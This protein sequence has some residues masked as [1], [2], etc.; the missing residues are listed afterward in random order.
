MYALAGFR[1]NKKLPYLRPLASSRASTQDQLDRV[2]AHYSLLLLR[3]NQLDQRMS[4]IA[5]ENGNQKPSQKHLEELGRMLR[6]AYMTLRHT[7]HLR[8]KWLMKVQDGTPF[9]VPP[10]YQ[11]AVDAL[12]RMREELGIPGTAVEEQVVEDQTEEVEDPVSVSTTT[13]ST[14][15][16]AVSTSTTQAA[17]DTS[18]TTV[19]AAGL[20]TTTSTT[21]S[22]ADLTSQ[23]GSIDFGTNPLS[24]F[25]GVTGE[26]L[27]PGTLPLTGNS[28]ITGPLG[29]GMQNPITNPLLDIGRTPLRPGGGFDTSFRF[30]RPSTSGRG[31]PPAPVPTNG[32]RIQQSINSRLA[33]DQISSQSN[34]GART[35]AP[36]IA[37]QLWKPLPQMPPLSQTQLSPRTNPFTSQSGPNTSIP[38]T[39]L[40]S[41][42]NQV[43]STAGNN[44]FT[45]MLADW[46][47]SVVGNQPVAR[48]SYDK[49][50][51]RQLA[52]FT[53]HPVDFPRF[54]D[55]FLEAVDGSHHSDAYK[56][57][58]LINKLDD[59]SKKLVVGFQPDYYQEALGVLY[60]RFA[61]AH[62]VTD[63]IYAT[64][65]AMPNMVRC[66]DPEVVFEQFCVVKGILT[67]IQRQNLD[68]TLE[69]Y[70][71]ETVYQKFPKKMGHLYIDAQSLHTPRLSPYLD[72]IEQSLAAFMGRARLDQKLAMR[73]SGHSSS[74]AQRGQIP[75]VRDSTSRF[76]RQVQFVESSLSSPPPSSTAVLATSATDQQ[77]GKVKG[78]CAGCKGNHGQVMCPQA[79]NKIKKQIVYDCHLCHCCFEPG[80]QAKDCPS[81][82][83]C[84][85]CQ[86]LHCLVMCK[87]LFNQ[88][89][90]PLNKKKV[91]L[92][93]ASD[94]YG[95]EEE[96][97]D[98]EG[99]V[100]HLQWADDE[101]TIEGFGSLFHTDGQVF[102][103][104]S[105]R[106]RV[107]MDVCLNG[108][109]CRALL[110]T[111]SDHNL[112]PSQL[113]SK[114]QLD[115]VLHPHTLETPGDHFR[116]ELV[117]H[118][119]LSIGRIRRRA[120]FLV[121]NKDV[122]VVGCSALRSFY[123]CVN[124]QMRISQLNKQLEF[125]YL[126]EF[127]DSSDEE[128]VEKT[129][130]NTVVL[131]PASSPATS[132]RMSGTVFGVQLSSPM[133][134]STS[135]D[136]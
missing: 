86:G 81:K 88:A 133:T 108:Y 85:R 33:A 94:D 11:Q 49:E 99:D 124:H 10:E 34:L 68:L 25:G 31:L 37:K 40:S 47:R 12:A 122:V 15:S 103:A 134:S 20:Q 92:V 132:R 61:S 115:T 130:V 113:A 51:Y 83:Y 121:Y 91:H 125:Q 116:T 23:F 13:L 109:K 75:S 82:C 5:E 95:S 43:Q 104:S 7:E 41:S 2:K 27:I 79:P 74:S 118:A 126:P 54:L 55:G 119:Q 67:Q 42:Q 63:N 135:A 106:T 80:H 32:D 28:T 4:Q 36:T 112:I 39:P 73:D 117:T 69:T 123:L 45:D 59:K 100:A 136:G 56:L 120:K 53:G 114:L 77:K 71:L 35:P 76:R 19:S 107:M 93:H 129:C 84:P 38:S 102:A 111:G 105:G 22:E 89:G 131:D 127:E 44:P 98:T 17:V 101:D 1:S 3:T 96:A 26:L 57:S 50:M 30:S 29:T 24:G 6:D 14:T 65:R 110:D 128:E 21:T 62:Q 87:E 58:L 78:P 97:S 90:P 48:R 64:L 60:V 18:T 66:R 8:V 16:T 72:A 46:V 9:P 70:V 52:T